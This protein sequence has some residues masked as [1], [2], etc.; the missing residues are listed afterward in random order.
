MVCDFV[1]RHIQSF[2]LFNKWIF[3]P[4]KFTG[5][6]LPLALSPVWF[7]SPWL[8]VS[9][10]LQL[11]TNS[12]SWQVV[13]SNFLKTQKKRKKKCKANMFSLHTSGIRITIMCQDASLLLIALKVETIYSVLY[14]LSLMICCAKYSLIHHIQWRT[15]R[16]S[17]A[18]FNTSVLAYSLWTGAI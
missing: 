13:N 14:S 10:R 9:R 3:D 16:R 7:C 15:T 1:M 11:T 6:E 4:T 12:E 2:F 18:C 17:I 5:Q 8:R